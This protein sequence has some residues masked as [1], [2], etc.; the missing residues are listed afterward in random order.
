L[1]ADREIAGGGGLL[2]P[3]SLD[4]DAPASFRTRVG[5][6]SAKRFTVHADTT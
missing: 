4:T 3:V 5:A 6:V 2:L 1:H